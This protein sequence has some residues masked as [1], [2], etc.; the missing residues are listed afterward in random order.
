MSEARSVSTA[1]L[2][3]IVVSGSDCFSIV[4]D[5]TKLTN[6]KWAADALSMNSGGQDLYGHEEL[7]P[8][9]QQGHKRAGVQRWERS[10][11]SCG[12]RT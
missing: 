10:S 5:P 11:R 8:G 9:L 4:Y 3:V 7:C 1:S 2:R 12:S 6:T